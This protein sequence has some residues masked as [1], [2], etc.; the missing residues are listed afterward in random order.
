MGMIC[1]GDLCGMFWK[2][3][4]NFGHSMPK[5]HHPYH[6]GLGEPS[7]CFCIVSFYLFPRAFERRVLPIVGVCI[8]SSHL[9]ICSS[10]NLLIFTPAR[11]HIFSSSHLLIFTSAHLYICSS[12]HLLI[13]TPAHLHTCSSSHLLIF[14]SAHLH[15]CSSSHLLI[16]TSAHLAHLHICSSSHLLIFTPAHLHICSS[17]HLLIFTSA[18]LHICLFSLPFLSLAFFIFLSLGRGWY[19]RRVTKC[20]P[21]R[22]K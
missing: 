2:P 8:S 10:S 13:F 18:H 6:Q 22:T 16:F 1:F 12:S 11:L 5:L 3:P 15:I 21:F 9:H 19:R 20:Q 4:P 14:T 7:C 17:S